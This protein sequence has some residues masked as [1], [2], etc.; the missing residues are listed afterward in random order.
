MARKKTEK[1]NMIR[2]KGKSNPPGRQ[3]IID[4]FKLLL[5]KK[6]F[7]SITLSD[8]ATNA[9]VTEALIYKYFKD[10]R[11]LMYQILGVYLLD[12]I[13]LAQRDLKGIRDTGFG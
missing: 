7:N 4:S 8:I 10:K 9:G 2:I 6:D 3:K 1:K 11:D 13:Q 12:V 5:E